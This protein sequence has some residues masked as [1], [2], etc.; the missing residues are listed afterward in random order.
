MGEETEGE[1]QKGR[2]GQRERGEG[3]G[4]EVNICEIHNR[5]I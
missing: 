3:R 5:V 4:G 2:E 1:R